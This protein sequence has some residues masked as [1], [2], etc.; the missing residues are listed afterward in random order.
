MVKVKK[1]LFLVSFFLV[2]FLLSIIMLM[3]KSKYTYIN[4]LLMLLRFF[5]YILYYV[6]YIYKESI[7]YLRILFYK[8]LLNTETYV[9]SLLKYTYY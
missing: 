7:K 8:L 3:L 1:N 5:I 6:N 2:K 4:T 9:Y